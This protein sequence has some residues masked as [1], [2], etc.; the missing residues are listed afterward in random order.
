MS[1]EE[2]PQFHI[3]RKHN[4]S[5]KAQR[6]IPDAYDLAKPSVPC[7]YQRLFV[8]EQDEFTVKDQTENQDLLQ[9]WSHSMFL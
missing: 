2:T 3:P 6:R 8:K 9:A 4:F 1:P 7:P 5:S